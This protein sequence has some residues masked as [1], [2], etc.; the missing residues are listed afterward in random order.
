[1]VK[2]IQVR[3]V[4]KNRPGFYRT[5]HI[6]NPSLEARRH[7]ATLGFPAWRVFIGLRGPTGST[8]PAPPCR[9]RSVT[10]T[11]SPTGI[12]LNGKRYNGSN[13]W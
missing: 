5:R 6:V 13:A 3:A 12:H 7:L 9:R 11:S 1:M 4:R 8:V 10:L 2:E